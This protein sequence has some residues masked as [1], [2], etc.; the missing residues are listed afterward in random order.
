[1]YGSF[2]SSIAGGVDEFS[3]WKSAFH[4]NQLIAA[5]ASLYSFERPSGGA[6]FLNGA[7]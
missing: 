4:R 2:R 7:G 3:H 5:V 6:G 1:M